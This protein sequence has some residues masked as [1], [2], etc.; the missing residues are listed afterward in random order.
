MNNRT[1]KKRIK[2]EKRLQ[3]GIKKAFKSGDDKQLKNANRLYLN[4]Y[5]PKYK[6]ATE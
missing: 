6:A 1:H 3:E 4:S 5:A 2:H